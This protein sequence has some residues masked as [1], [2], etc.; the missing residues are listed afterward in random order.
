MSNKLW[1]SLC[2]VPRPRRCLNIR[3]YIYIT[4]TNCSPSD[5]GIGAAVDG[6]DV[7]LDA[8]AGF[9]ASLSLFKNSFESTA[10]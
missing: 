8:A 6:A 9:F 3:N 5:S 4:K 10:F 1:K 7:V 2:T